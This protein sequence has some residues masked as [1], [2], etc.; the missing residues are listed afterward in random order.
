MAAY[1]FAEEGSI[2]KEAR[3]VIEDKRPELSGLRRAGLFVLNLSQSLPET[4]R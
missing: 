4:P 3:R 2:P 1:G